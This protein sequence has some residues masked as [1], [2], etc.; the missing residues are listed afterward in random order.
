[1][2]SIHASQRWFDAHKWPS[3]AMHKQAVTDFE[4]YKKS[5]IF[6]IV[7]TKIFIDKMIEKWEA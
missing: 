7:R 5:T 4:N 6:E 3:K 2:C 1:M